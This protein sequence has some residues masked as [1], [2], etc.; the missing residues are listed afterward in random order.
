M[1]VVALF[2]VKIDPNVVYGFG[3]AV[4][5]GLFGI[6]NL[7]LMPFTDNVAAAPKNTGFSYTAGYVVGLCVIPWVVRQVLKVG[8]L[9]FK[10]WVKR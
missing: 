1:T 8:L 2:F 10:E 7:I 9:L 4:L 3:P 6:P 5:H